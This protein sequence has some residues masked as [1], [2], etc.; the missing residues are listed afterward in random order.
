MNTS[1]GVTIAK[2]RPGEDVLAY[3]QRVD[4]RVD[5]GRYQQII[6]AANPYK[7]GDEAIGV[8]AADDPSRAHARTLLANTAVRVVHEQPL[9][10]DAL[11]QLIWHTTD[12]AAYETVKDW[13]FGALKAFLLT[14][15]E[16]AIKGIMPGLSSDVI[17]VVTKL[18]SNDDL[19]AIG[20][21]LFNPLPG[22]RLGAKGYMGARIQPNSPTDHPDDI[23]WQIFNGFA[24]ATGDVV[25]GINP[26]DSSE[27][28]IAALE[29]TLQD[30]VDTFGLAD[31]LPWCVLAHIDV[32]AAVKAAE[33][34]AVT[35]MFQSLAGTE[36][37]NAIFDLTIDKMVRHVRSQTGKYGLYI[38]TGQGADFT[39]GAAHGFDMV[40]HEARKYGFARALQQELEAVQPAGAWLHVNDVAGFIGPEVFTTREQLVRAAL[41]DIAMGKLHGLMIGLDVC[42]TLH[43][44][45]SRD[46]LEWALDRIMPANP[47]YLMALPTQNDPMLSYLTTS[48]QSHVRIRDTFGYRVDDAMWSFYQR[49]GI[50]D[51]QGQ[52][53]EHAGDP[54]WVYYQY[55]LAKGDPRSLEAIYAEGR[56][57]VQEVEARH[58]PL[59]QGYG[60]RLWDMKPE[61]TAQLDGL[62]ADA[63]A[64][65]WTELTPGF[66]EALPHAVVLTTEAPDR[67]DYMIR[68]VHGEHLSAPAI[69]T[70]KHLRTTWGDDVPDVQ[71]VISDGLNASALMDDGHLAPY[72]EAV[73]PALQAAGWTVSH[74][75]IVVINGRVRAGYAIGE[76][77]FEQTAA[78]APKAIVHIIGERPGTGHHNYSVYV[79]APR[80]ELWRDKAVDHHLVRVIS[81]ISDTATPPGVAVE[82]TVRILGELQDLN[83]LD[84]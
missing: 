1:F 37:A 29:K 72:L 13:T 10:V 79:A 58:V 35:L 2:P 34:S 82:M 24:F 28:N 70:L 78:D 9:F 62:Y 53:T 27:A 80:A 5:H 46:D 74:A 25:L 64:S 42:S 14:Q 49:L 75:P 7:E 18:M 20:Q 65:L 43:M 4:G 83:R 50:I 69:E 16:A 32:Q 84:P 52:F 68:P 40:V 59:A 22:S 71:L 31:I 76:V 30:I 19:I 41:E 57:K 23:R 55:C 44:H 77:L 21:T 51:A 45:I 38:E 36:D 12:A 61:L 8:S 81:G 60:A 11:Q 67:E 3:L 54:I 73:Q 56:Q 47:G 6:G 17:A 26:V 15:S 66:I 33:P 63:K 48:F 39:N